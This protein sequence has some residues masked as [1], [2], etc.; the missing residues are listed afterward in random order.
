MEVDGRYPGHHQGQKVCLQDHLLEPMG[1][2]QFHPID[3][4]ETQL[5]DFDAFNFTHH[6]DFDDDEP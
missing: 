5:N 4:E 1:L 3:P 6:H 2:L